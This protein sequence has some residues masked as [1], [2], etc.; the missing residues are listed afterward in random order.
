M[1]GRRH[2]SP[3]RWRKTHQ[4]CYSNKSEEGL[5][6]NLAKKVSQRKI[7][8]SKEACARQTGCR[9]EERGGEKLQKLGATLPW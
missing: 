8:T 4:R 2:T 6:R 3:I 5:V 7:R 1:N 9:E